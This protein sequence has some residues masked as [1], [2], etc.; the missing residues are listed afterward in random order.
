MKKQYRKKNQW[1][2]YKLFF[3]NKHIKNTS[4][5]KFLMMIKICLRTYVKR[6]NYLFIFKFEKVLFKN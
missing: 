3:N 4:E 1:F 5:K 2:K 6:N